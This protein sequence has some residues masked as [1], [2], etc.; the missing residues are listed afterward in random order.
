MK[1]GI[2]MVFLV[3]C[4]AAIGALVL[5]KSRESQASSQKPQAETVDLDIL[6]AKAES[7]DPAA[8]A[9]L[10]KI[11]Q[12]GALVK[13]DIP[14]AVKWF[15][16][17]ADQNYPDAFAALGE[18]T[19]AG[20]GVPR[21]IAEAVHLYRMAAGKGSIA[22]QYNLGYLYEQGEG[23][24]KDEIEAAKWYQLAAEGGDPI[25]QYD[26]GQRLTL[27]VGMATNLVQAFKWLSLA[28]AQGQSDSARLL[29]TLEVKMSKEEISEGN[30]LVKEFVPRAPRLSGP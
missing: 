21:N 17:A 14:E 10:G 18:M 2:I 30:R 25:A 6:K 8:Q 20:Q 5:R 22:G 19:Q 16:R 23:V 4:A 15:Q 26:I 1:K 12:E 7:G 27:G 29:P 11:Y 3:C 13:T 28:A 9:R 24:D